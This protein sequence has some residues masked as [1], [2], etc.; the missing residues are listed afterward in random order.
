MF[1]DF[2]PLCR[3]IGAYFSNGMLYAS[4]LQPA[5]CWVTSQHQHPNPNVGLQRVFGLK[6][7]KINILRNFNKCVYILCIIPCHRN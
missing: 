7:K 6:F 4:G 1:I 3:V 2:L 5:E